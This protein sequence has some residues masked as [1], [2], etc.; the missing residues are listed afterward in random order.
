[1]ELGA[2]SGVGYLFEGGSFLSSDPGVRSL[3]CF[4]GGLSVCLGSCR[5]RGFLFGLE[6]CSCLCLL[7]FQQSGCRL[8]LLPALCSSCRKR[9]LFRL[10]R[11]RRFL[12]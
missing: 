11:S 8:C 2:S 7:L 9:C 1:L 12:F 3:S 5:S 6:G 4:F 10:F